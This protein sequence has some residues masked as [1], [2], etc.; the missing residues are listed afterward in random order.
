MLPVATMRPRPSRQVR[1]ARPAVKIIIMFQLTQIVR[2]LLEHDL[3]FRYKFRNLGFY[4]KKF[5]LFPR[6]VLAVQ[7]G[8]SIQAQFQG[9]LA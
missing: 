2:F 5:F 1:Q 9:P 8:L 7:H 3:R 4:K 6:V